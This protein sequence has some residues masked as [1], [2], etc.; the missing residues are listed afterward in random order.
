MMDYIMSASPWV[1]GILAL[2][3]GMI[4]WNLIK[5]GQSNQVKGVSKVVAILLAVGLAINLGWIAMDPGTETPTGEVLGP[6]VWEA[7]PTSSTDNTSVSGDDI[8]THYTMTAG[9]FT[10]AATGSVTISF[11]CTRTDMSISDSVAT[12]YVV[13]VPSV[14]NT[15]SGV[16]HPL[17]SS[18][19]NGVF[20][21]DFTV[22][23][24]TTPMSMTY[25]ADNEARVATVSL[26]IVFSAAAIEAIPQYGTVSIQYSIGGEI[27]THDIMH[28]D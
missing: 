9:A 15:S 18:D 24:V 13:S 25:P 16:S 4:G 23:G 17:V 28:M 6:A 8:L 11:A 7:T 5:S 1:L 2:I 14:T 27:F 12:A 19:A 26:T 21:A 3:A 10:D 20:D 22:S